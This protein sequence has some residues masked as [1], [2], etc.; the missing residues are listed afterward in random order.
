M[1][2][3][4]KKNVPWSVNGILADAGG[5][6]KVAAASIPTAGGASIETA[7]STKANDLGRLTQEIFDDATYP[8]PYFGTT[9]DLAG[10]PSTG[11]YRM[12]YIP[13]FANVEG[14]AVQVAVGAVTNAG[15]HWRKSHGTTWL[16]WEDAATATKPTEHPLPLAA[17]ITAVVRCKYRRNQEHEATTNLRCSFTAG[18][19]GGQSLATL[20]PGYRPADIVTATCNI[21]LTNGSAVTGQIDIRPDGDIVVYPHTSVSGSGSVIMSPVS[22]VAV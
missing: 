14:Y 10:Q 11:Q 13:Y 17:G 20:P 12:I 2:L 18:L 16:E 5:D 6:I 8:H 19:V 4:D 1:A 9:I 22:F 7:L 15:L 3:G 21:V